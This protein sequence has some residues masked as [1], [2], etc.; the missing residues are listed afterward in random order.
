LQQPDLYYWEGGAS[1]GHLFRV[2]RF[3][4]QLQGLLT[5]NCHVRHLSTEGKAG[6]QERKKGKK[7][8]MH[9]CMHAG[10]EEITRPGR[11]EERK[12][13]VHRQI[14]ER[15]RE[16]GVMVVYNGSE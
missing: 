9:A 3:H 2:A 8:G 6:S 16:R 15:E 14:T 11:K 1:K 12:E 4:D 5:I 10:R 13:R 7:D